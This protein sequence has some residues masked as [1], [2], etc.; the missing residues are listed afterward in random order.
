M[1]L[2]LF[3]SPG[4]DGGGWK[5]VRE[6]GQ[7]RGR[8][9]RLAARGGQRLSR[10]SKQVQIV[11]G[12]AGRRAPQLPDRPRP[13]VPGRLFGR[14]PHRLRRRLRAA[15]T[16][17][18]RD[19]DLR[20]RQP[21]RRILAPSAAAPAASVSPSSLA[22]RTSTAARSNACAAPTSRKSAYAARSGRSPDSAT[23]CRTTRRW[24]KRIDGSRRVNPGSP[25]LAKKHPTARI[26]PDAGDEARAGP[27]RRSSSPRARA[28]SPRRAGS[29]PG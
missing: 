23:R 2:I 3:L 17:R 16:V 12:R 28:A 7:G 15:G 14:R 29:T 27:A 24:A 19:A 20:R 22:R 21:A 4:N 18:R 9:G 25:R 11:L 5:G 26:A 8:A 10:P 6:V 1:P 13:D